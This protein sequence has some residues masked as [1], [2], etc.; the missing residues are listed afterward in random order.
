[1]SDATTDTTI[2]ET[3]GGPPVRETLD[4][5][6]AGLRT[7]VVAVTERAATKMKEFLAQEDAASQDVALRVA[8]Q[9]GGCAGFQYAL[10]FDDRRLDG[11]QEA[12]QHGVTV[13]VDAQSANH[14]RGATIDWKE[15]LE[16]SGF[17]IDNPSASSSCACGESFS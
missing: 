13:R 11:D 17:Q 9:A 12:V 10:F 8:V 7:S 5:P 6:P 16:A 2:K 14:L 15:S 3:L 1:M 4:G